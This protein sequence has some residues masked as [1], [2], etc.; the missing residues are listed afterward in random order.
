MARKQEIIELDGK[1]YRV[2]EMPPLMVRQV[3]IKWNDSLAKNDLGEEN[4]ALFKKIL[5]N[6]EVE[7][8]PN[9]WLKLDTEDAINENVSI[10]S[11][12]KLGDKVVD[13]SVGFLKDGENSQ[14]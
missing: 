10:Q 4:Q 9:V 5:S 14:S 12:L 1:K 6:V 3:F 11:M 7:T 8:S 13:L 2:N